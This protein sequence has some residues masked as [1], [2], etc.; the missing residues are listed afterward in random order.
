MVMTATFS[1]LSGGALIWAHAQVGD[2]RV[3]R[4]AVGRENAFLA[5]IRS[6]RIVS[7]LPF[8]LRV[9]L[10]PQTSVGSVVRRCVR[11]ARSVLRLC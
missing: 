6:I 10:I 11:G 4:A 7:L 8:Q 3:G 5:V 9:V 1:P 2:T